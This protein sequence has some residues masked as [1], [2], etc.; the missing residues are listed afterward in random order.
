MKEEPDKP[1]EGKYER[2]GHKPQKLRWLG[3]G[4]A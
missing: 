3:G 4:A 2:R 1:T